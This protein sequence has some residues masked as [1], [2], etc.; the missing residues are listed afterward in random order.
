M[1]SYCDGSGVCRNEECP[2]NGVACP[3]PETEGVCAHEDREDAV[4]QLTP[5][6]CATLALLQ[7]GLIDDISDPMIDSFFDK[8]YAIMK[9]NGYI[10]EANG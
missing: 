6:G 1:C 10:E 2:L 4:Y 7:C 5:K 8:F 3:V 9:T